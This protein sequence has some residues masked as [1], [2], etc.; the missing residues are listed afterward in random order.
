MAASV[1]MKTEYAV[2]PQRSTENVVYPQKMRE[3]STVM[4]DRPHHG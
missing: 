4:V 2:Y 1:L 3:I